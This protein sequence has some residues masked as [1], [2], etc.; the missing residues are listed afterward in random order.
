MDQFSIAVN[1]HTLGD[2]DLNSQF[3][4]SEVWVLCSGPVSPV[5]PEIMV[6]SHSFLELRG[7]S[8]ARVAFGRSSVPL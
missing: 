2:I 3:C 5:R 1:Y 6:Q 4:G 8:Q 7:L